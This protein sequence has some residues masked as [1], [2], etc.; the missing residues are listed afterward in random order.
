MRMPVMQQQDLIPP[1]HPFLPPFHFNHQQFL[2]DANAAAATIA[3]L[4][5]PQQHQQIT[6]TTAM[7][8]MASLLQAAAAISGQVQRD[9]C[10]VCNDKVICLLSVEN[11]QINY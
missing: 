11:F 5:N 2:S 9:L 3:A 7:P 10:Q 1:M 6:A 8:S 4:Y